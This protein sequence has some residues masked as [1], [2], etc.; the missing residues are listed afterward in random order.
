[1]EMKWYEKRAF[2]AYYKREKAFCESEGL[3]GYMINAPSRNTELLLDVDGKDYLILK[4]CNG[5]LAIYNVDVDKQSI[6]YVKSRRVWKIAE[7]M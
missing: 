3:V 1:M 4:N 2:T 7:E 5:P 6:K